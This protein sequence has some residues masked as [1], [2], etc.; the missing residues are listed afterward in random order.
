V[1]RHI[2]E[3]YSRYRSPEGMMNGIMV[4]SKF[5]HATSRNIDPQLHSHVFVVNA[6]RTP[7]GNWRANE[8][9]AIYQ[10]LKSLGF[11]Y[12]QELARELR[13]RSFEIEIQDVPRCSS[14]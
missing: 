12:R 8:P 2:E 4:A 1:L 11:L 13:A 5:D 6:V 14:S 3:H 9:K 10:D 7:D